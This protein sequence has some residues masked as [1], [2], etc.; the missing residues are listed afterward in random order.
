LNWNNDIKIRNDILSLAENYPNIEFVFRG[1][2]YDWF[3]N[4]FHSKVIRRTKKL[5]NVIVDTNYDDSFRSYHLCSSA[6][7]IIARPT[8]LAEE[9]MSNGMNVIVL[10]YGI[11]YES[12]VSRWMPDLLQG[13]YCHSLVQLNEMFDFFVKNKTVIPDE[14]NRKIRK[15]VFS[16][17]TDGKVKER[18][19][20]NLNLIYSL[21]EGSE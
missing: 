10:D 6:D 14:D 17:L 7:L 21:Q 8:S 12:S 1:K 18:I 4:E 5:R 3:S 11:N 9:C 16:N 15:N 13:Y 19:Q 20:Y 2:N